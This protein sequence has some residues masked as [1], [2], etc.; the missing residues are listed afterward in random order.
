YQQ[1]YPIVA[2]GVLL[3]INSIP[4]ALTQILGG[5]EAQRPFIK[6]LMMVLQ[7]IGALCC[8]VLFISAEG[9]AKIMGDEALTPM[10]RAASVSFL[11]VGMLGVLRGYF[12]AKF[13]MNPPAF[14]QVIEQMIRVGMI[15][16]VIL[17]F[18]QHQ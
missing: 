8:I 11:I 17:L 2:L 3:A 18:T 13:E 10:I 12:Q 5:A 7:I 6:K 16:I 4:S 9:I 1:I 14:S 15:G